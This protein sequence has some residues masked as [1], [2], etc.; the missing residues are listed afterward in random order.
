VICGAGE[1]QH[2]PARLCDLSTGGARIDLLAPLPVG[3]EL[4]LTVLQAE[5]LPTVLNAS[6]SRV[7]R[8]RWG[9]EA[10]CTFSPSLTENQLAAVLA[11]VGSKSA[12]T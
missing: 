5:G 11:P 2:R 9:W 12:S 4:R 10:G 3:A 6:V 7:S 8:T 1:Q